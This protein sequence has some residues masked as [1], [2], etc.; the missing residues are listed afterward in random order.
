MSQLM[1]F[2]MSEIREMWDY[3]RHKKNIK[4]DEEEKTFLKVLSSLC[5]SSAKTLNHVVEKIG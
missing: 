1:F 2:K 3:V 4:V 5:T